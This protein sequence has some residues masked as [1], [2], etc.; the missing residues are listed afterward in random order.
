MGVIRLGNISIYLSEPFVNGFTAGAAVHVFTSQFPKLFGIN[1]HR[2]N[3]PLAQIY[4]SINIK[5]V[6]FNNLGNNIGYR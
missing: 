2:Y 1:V 4:A 5:S 6:V 3:G